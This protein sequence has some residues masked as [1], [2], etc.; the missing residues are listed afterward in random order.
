MLKT[1]KIIKHK[2]KKGLI[3]RVNDGGRTV[4]IK[5]LFKKETNIQMFTGLELFVPKTG[6]KGKIQGTFGKTGKIKAVF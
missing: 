5:D 4:I 1:L 6:A 3:D 2:C